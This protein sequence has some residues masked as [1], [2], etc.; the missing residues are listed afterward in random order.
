MKQGTQPVAW[1]EWDD[2]EV[3]ATAVY[4][5]AFRYANGHS[6]L[7]RCRITVNGRRDLTN[8]PTPSGTPGYPFDGTYAFCKTNGWNVWRELV[9]GIELQAGRN[10]IRVTV[11]NP[12]GAPLIDKITVGQPWQP[13]S[14]TVLPGAHGWD[15]VPEILARISPPVFPPQ[16]WLI[17]DHGAKTDGV[18]DALPV[19]NQTIRA[20]AAAGGGR[21]VVPTGDFCLKGTVLLASRVNL[22]L[23]AGARL[24]FRGEKSDYGP[25]VLTTT[26][27]NLCYKNSLIY[28]YGLSDVALTGEGSTSVIDGGQAQLTWKDGKV[29]HYADV[30][31]FPE[32]RPLDECRPNGIDLFRCQKVLLDGYRLQN[33]PF[34]G[35]VLTNCT[36][37]T[38]RHLD[39]DSHFSNNDGIDIQSCR[40]VLVEDCR[41]DTKDDCIC[42]KAGRDRDGREVL[43]S[44]QNVVI[45]RNQLATECSHLGLGSEMSGGLQQVFVDEAGVNGK[46]VVKAN[47]D[48]GG[49][50]GQ[51]FVRDCPQI[52]T[53]VMNFENYNYRG[54]YDPPVYDGFSFENL[55]G[56]KVVSLKGWVDNL[57]RNVSFRH[58]GKPEVTQ[59][60][61]ENV[62]FE[63]TKP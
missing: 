5:V 34:W 54:Y 42:L 49:S 30:G 50:V 45:R 17:T 60:Y 7:N 9:I 47:Y 41:F 40:D 25:R 13:S 53:V 20:C 52:H 38:V 16:D 48:R 46:V 8:N 39:V 15:R 11:E 58:C 63:G 18:T 10:T 22:H 2:V 57:I 12:E 3:P 36:N 59:I 31:L 62:D 43:G 32:D 28:G 4:Q 1:W 24:L 14:V 55:T 23:A 6:R 33:Y 35:N 61:T 56:L 37:V 44:C 19:L 29:H 27:G 21:V 51:V 26:E